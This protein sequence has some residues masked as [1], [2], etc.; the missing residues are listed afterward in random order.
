MLFRSLGIKY[1]A[2]TDNDITK[3]PKS[4][5]NI[6]QTLG[7]SR[8]NSLIAELDSTPTITLPTETNLPKRATGARAKKERYNV[9]KS[10]IDSINNTYGIFLSRCDLETDLYECL[11]RR[12]STIMGKN[13]VKVLKS[14]KQYKM[15]ELA[16]QL[17]LSDCQKIYEHKNFA[18]LKAVRQ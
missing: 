8:V 10:I 9:N 17:T 7:F 11:G 13:P 1:V 14:S 5:P 6:Y 2:K 16:S 3:V 4:K 15:V 12:L 18:C